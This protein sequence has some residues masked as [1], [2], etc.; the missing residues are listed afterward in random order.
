MAKVYY[1]FSQMSKSPNP[2][3]LCFVVE[4]R[5]DGETERRR[6]GE[7]ERRR[8]G[9]T[10]RRTP[11]LLINSP[12]HPT[13]SPLALFSSSR[14]W[15]RGRKYLMK[16]WAD[17]SGLPVMLSKAS[18]QDFE[19]PRPIMSLENKQWVLNYCQK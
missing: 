4:R 2:L 17:I 5:R 8:D 14:N 6:D 3:G 12:P 13:H 16:D 19:N 18:G 10:G 11:N 9:E 15:Y 7:K 1:S